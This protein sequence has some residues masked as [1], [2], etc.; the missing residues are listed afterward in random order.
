VG[1]VEASTDGVTQNKESGVDEQDL[2]GIEWDDCV[3]Y[4]RSG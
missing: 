1:T 3:L 2:W 4:I